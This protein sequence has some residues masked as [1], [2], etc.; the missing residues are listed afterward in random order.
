MGWIIVKFG[1][2]YVAVGEAVS[3]HWSANEIGILLFT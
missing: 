2:D 3:R 1:K